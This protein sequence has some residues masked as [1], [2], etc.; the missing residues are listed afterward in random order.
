M[1]IVFAAITP[2]S[3]LLLP[4]IGKEHLGQ[5]TQTSAAFELL[6]QDFYASQVE[7]VIVISPHGPIKNN[8]FLFNQA[9]EFKANLEKFGDFST[10]TIFRGD[11]GLIHQIR[12]E[13]ETTAALNL[14]SEEDLD[15]GTL[16]PLEL[17]TTNT[18]PQI[19]PL[20][21][22]NADLAAHY[23]FG[24]QLKRLLISTSKNVGIIAS[25]DLSHRHTTTTPAG[26]SPKAGKFDIKV[27]ELLQKNQALDLLDLKPEL[28]TEVSE[29]GLKSIATLLGILDGIKTTPQKLSYEAPFGVGY[30]TLRYNF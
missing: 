7:T 25:G 27:I 17:I 21:V 16:I 23:E 5:L 26:Y 10:K 1:S 11:V 19:I 28:L 18:K 12:E 22:S 29:C 14:I 24:K 3:P 9:P 2:H 15:F 13:L 30:L 8:A 6:A 4:T 20:Y